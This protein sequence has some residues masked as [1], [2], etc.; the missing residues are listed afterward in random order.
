MRFT[1]Q[2]VARITAPDTSGRQKLLWDDDLKGFGMLISGTTTARSWV[3]Q[4]AL[5]NGNRRRITIGAVNV[6]TVEQA[7]DRAIGL[8]AQFA[9]RRDPKAEAQKERQRG[10]TLRLALAQYL[11]RTKL[12]PSS[13]ALYERE[14]TTHLGGWLDKPL[15]RITPDM[16]RQRHAEITRDLKSSGHSGNAVANNVLQR[17]RAIWRYAANSIDDLPP[18]PV[19]RGLFD[20]WHP[21]KRRERLLSD[22]SLRPWYEALNEL[23][24][25][26]TRDAL[27]LLLFTGM[28]LR[29]GTGLRWDE[30]DPAHRTITIS[31]N[32]TKTGDPLEIPMNSFVH[33]LLV[34]R[35]A[36]YG[37]ERGLV[38]PGVRNGHDPRHGILKVI[39]QTGIQFSPHDLR[40]TFVTTGE[41]LENIEWLALKTLVGHRVKDVTAGY[42][43]MNVERLRRP[44]QAIC[45][46]LM[47]L[48]G[49]T[50]D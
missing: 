41:S 12:R 32:R 47:Q 6:L 27:L 35:R 38:F 23:A 1:K 43:I 26:M 34:A 46:R 13:K 25:P 20:L 29:E 7:R 5:P 33:D 24:S 16:V 22:A 42:V 18:H 44:S 9:D 28:R 2:T 31:G 48:C 17:F 3:V 37:N 30:V 19:A 8:L 50:V 45:D 21:V 4:K 10:M 40:R 39:E 36:R 15:R 11:G 14:V 49:I